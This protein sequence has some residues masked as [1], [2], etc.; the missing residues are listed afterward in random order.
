MHMKTDRD[1]SIWLQCTHKAQRKAAKTVL[2]YL[3]EDVVTLVTEALVRS[4]FRR[5]AF[6][7]D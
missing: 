3:V 6:G 4:R 7:K 5:I 1:I 2:R